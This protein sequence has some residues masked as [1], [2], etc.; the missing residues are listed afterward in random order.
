MGD[1]IVHLADFMIFSNC[2]LNSRDA[3]LYGPGKEIWRRSV[4]DRPT[5]QDGGTEAR[6]IL[7]LNL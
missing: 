7:S 1:R 6:A 2:Y 4:R 5:R 3:C